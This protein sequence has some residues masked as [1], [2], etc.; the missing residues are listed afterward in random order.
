MDV[1]LGLLQRALSYLQ[2]IKVT[3]VI[4]IAIISYIFYKILQFARETRAG[5]VLRGVALVIGL[6]WLSD[7][8]NLHVLSYI[9]SK[10]VELGFL[11]LIV[12]FQPEIRHFLEQVGSRQLRL[13][14]HN[15]ELPGT[16]LEAAIDQTVEAYAAM[17]KDKVGALMVFERNSI[18][19][20]CLNS[21][22]KLDA[23]VTGELLKNIFWPKAP[24]HD[25]A[26]IVRGGRVV[27]AGCMLPLSGNPKISKELGMRHRAGIGVTEHTDAVAVICS[28]ETGSISVAVNGIL[29]RH[30]APETLARMLKNEL[31]L[32]EEEESRK[33]AFPFGGRNVRDVVDLFRGRKGES[34]GVE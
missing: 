5:Q 25:G 8:C 19:D 21:G 27:G 17:S 20:N 33:W 23:A 30:L 7:V 24:M 11:A 15:E 4:D 31:L 10:T 26:V 12:V 1:L 34:D 16:E 14:P 22:T 32:S 3:D 6:L 28:E 9:L 2:T 29:R 18:L 13:T